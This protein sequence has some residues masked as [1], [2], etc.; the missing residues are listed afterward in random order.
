MNSKLA[1]ALSVLLWLVSVAVA[2]FE[3]IPVRDALLLLYGWIVSWGA[4]DLATLYDSY[5]SSV[6]I[7]QILTIVLAIVVLALAVF[8]G[9][10]QA[11]HGATPK[12][13][14]LFAWIFGVEALIFL[15]L[16]LIP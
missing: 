14:R 5:W 13:W 6:F 1:G 11:K 10:Y 16:F 12:I 4:T 15:L 7:G 3:L 8:V 9:E 2:I